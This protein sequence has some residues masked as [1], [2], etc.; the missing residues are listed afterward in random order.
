MLKQ[1]INKI[2]SKLKG[3]RNNRKYIAISKAPTG[4]NYE[5][6]SHLHQ[7]IKPETYLEIGVQAG[8]SIIKAQQETNVIGIDPLDCIMYKLP[9]NIKMFFQ[10]SDDF[11]ERKDVSN[12]LNHKKIDL[13]FIDGMHLFE[14][15][16]RDFINIEKLSGPNTVITLH[17]CIPS[18]AYTSS[19]DF[20]EG[21]WT[22]DVFKIILVLK[23]YRP[24]L[25]IYNFNDLC[26]VTNVNPLNTILKENY[27]EIVN[28][29]IDLTYDDIADNKEE[30]LSIINKSPQEI[31]DEID[32]LL[33]EHKI[34]NIELL[35]K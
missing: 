6:L 12:I 8:N 3:K 26:V 17:D 22:G 29:Y 16:L 5:L 13:A 7:R 25:R 27:D 1:F 23:K 9:A 15:A 28:E 11:F 34:L 10:T 30:V 4:G 14:Y 21:S 24:D 33:I 32:I 20:H 18:D 31:K 35:A 2:F 19:R